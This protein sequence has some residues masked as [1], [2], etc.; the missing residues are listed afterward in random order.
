MGKLK[1]KCDYCQEWEGN[2]GQLLPHQM[3]CEGYLDFLQKELGE[4]VAD[5][6][7][8]LDIEINPHLQGNHTEIKEKYVQDWFWLYSDN[9]NWKWWWW[10]SNSWW[11]DQTCPK[12][13]DL[14][15]KYEKRMD[16]L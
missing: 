16:L 3:S 1:G 9:R 6:I 2:L 4:T 14:W 13:N 10:A 8:L 7:K 15:H 11:K 12:C 5:Q